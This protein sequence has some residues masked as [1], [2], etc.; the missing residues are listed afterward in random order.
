MLEYKVGLK[1]L[2]LLEILCMLHEKVVELHAWKMLLSKLLVVHC[3]GPVI[4]DM[5][6]HMHSTWYMV[7]FSSN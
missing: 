3:D 7:H 6:M 4:M 5:H 2:T 1:F